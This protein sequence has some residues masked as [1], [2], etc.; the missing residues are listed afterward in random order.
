MGNVVFGGSTTFAFGSDASL[1]IG[2]AEIED[3]AAVNVT[4]A[5]LLRIGTTKFMSKTQQA[6]FTVNGCPATQ[7]DQGWIVPKPGMRIIFR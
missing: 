2:S 6:H 7:N 3:S 4:G 1:S 5:N